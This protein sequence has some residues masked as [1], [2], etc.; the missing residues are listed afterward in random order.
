MIDRRPPLSSLYDFAP[1]APVLRLLLAGY[2]E[3]RPDGSARV[4]GRIGR[5]G[6]SLWLRGGMS[7]ERPAAVEHV[8]RALA[9]GGVEEVA[10]SAE[11]R[12]TGRTT[13]RLVW[14]CP[15]VEAAIGYP[16]LGVLVLVDGSLPGPWRRLPDRAPGTV[17][18]PSADLEL[19]E[20]TLRERMPDAIGATEEEIAAAEARL[21]VTLPDELKV[22]YRVTRVEGE[23]EKNWEG[24]YE[25]WE[26]ATEERNRASDA[27]GYEVSALHELYAVDPESRHSRWEFGATE[28]VATTPDAAVQGLAGSPGWIV[29]GSNGG[30]EI[31]VD[32]T[33][34]PGGHLG[35][36]I[37]VDHEQSLGAQLVADSFT[38]MVLGR[39]RKE[40]R[41]H[42]KDLPAVA[43][44]GGGDLSTVRAAAHPALEVLSLRAGDGAPFGLAP[45]TGLPR[46][47]TLTADPGTLADPLEITELAGLEFLE[48]GPQEWRALLDAGAVPRSLSAAAVREQGQDRGTVVAVANELLALWDRPRID[49]TVLEGDLLPEA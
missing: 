49:E 44:V 17:P 46:L 12:P 32:L 26:R 38:D 40:P 14:P 45:V 3:V 2:P 19:L 1:W 42:P 31:A 34:G 20:R 9:R 27:V 43:R 36:V 15:A 47:R 24:D 4:A 33:P 13:L 8:Q 22:F 25:T 23:E 41:V 5:H 7:S 18:A 39:E 28:G 37:L 6:Y 11:I 30:D 21:G 16:D 48:L 35:Q 10:F 29:F